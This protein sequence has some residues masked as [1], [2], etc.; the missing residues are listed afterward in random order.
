MCFFHRLSFLCAFLASFFISNQAL[1][2]PNPA[3]TFCIALD[4][5]LQNDAC[6]FPDGAHCE[7]WAFWRGECGT[8]YHLCT[9]RHGTLEQHQTI[10]V[11]RLNQKLYVW[12]VLKAPPS[13]GRQWTASLVPY[14]ASSDN[15]A[16]DPEKPPR[17]PD[18]LDK[19]TS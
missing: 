15:V 19:P 18:S 13:S 17:A 1:A 9:L 14:T 8:V 16:S 11:C 10:P 2:L 6:V 7:Q 4:Y 5:T 3:S 12:Q